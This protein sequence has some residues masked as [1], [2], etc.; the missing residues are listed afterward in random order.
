[1]KFFFAQGTRK[2]T[3]LILFTTFLVFIAISFKG[4]A[5]YGFEMA[6][7]E[8]GGR[9]LRGF[10]YPILKSKS[11]FYAGYLGQNA[12]EGGSEYIRNAAGETDYELFLPGLLTNIIIYGILVSPIVVLNTNR[13]YL[14]SSASNVL[15]K[16]GILFGSAKITGAVIIGGILLLLAFL[17]L[18]FITII[19]LGVFWI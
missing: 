11:V 12:I 17:V 13:H 4:L 14:I 3:I 5:Y 19:L 18:F 9:A 6:G 16:D 10:P 8:E 7:G 15:R 2:S 1:M